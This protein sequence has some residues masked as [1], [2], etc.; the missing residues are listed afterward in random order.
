MH[1]LV[2][3]PGFPTLSKLKKEKG[4]FY[5]GSF[6]L[7]EV[8]AYHSA[9]AIVTVLT[10]HVPGLPRKE[11]IKKGINVIRFR[12]F[13]PY[14]WQK[15][16]LP[17]HPL[18]SSKLLWLRMFQLPLF[19]LFFFISIYRFRHTIDI[20]HANWTPTALLAIPYKAI[21]NI[22][23]VL[24][25]RGSDLRLLPFIINKFIIR[26]VTAVLDIWGNMEFARKYQPYLRNKAVKLPLITRTIETSSMENKKRTGNKAQFVF[27]GRL[28]I[29]PDIHKG[30]DIIVPAANELRKKYEEFRVVILG[31]GPSKAFIQQ[32]IN[33]YNLSSHVELCG[34]R[35]DI[36]KFLSHSSAVIGGVGLN[37]VVTES[38]YSKALLLLPDDERWNNDIWVHKYNAL[39][40]HPETASALAEIMT[41]VIEQPDKCEQIALNGFKTIRK[42]VLDIKD[43]GKVYID[44]FH[45]IIGNTGKL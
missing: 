23:V 45:T 37:A 11:T 34:Y 32:Q 35:H 42:Y 15:V 38:A 43:G 22:P 4:N 28:S 21:F 24:T 9:G 6:V 44:A 5:G 18:Y 31:D 7:P 16:R 29:L 8:L 13:F 30:L 36:F 2:L 20:I 33:S 27:I 12:Y 19:I 3:A 1:I 17:K 25:Y 40:Y 26:K 10:P 41:Y 39:L 14:R